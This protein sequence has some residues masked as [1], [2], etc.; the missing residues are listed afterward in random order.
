M[1]LNKKSI[2]ALTLSVLLVLSVAAFAFAEN[3]PYDQNTIL[4]KSVEHPPVQDGIINGH[5]LNGSD[6]LEYG[7]ENP[8][9][10]L[11]KENNGFWAEDMNGNPLDYTLPS[12]IDLY[13]S[14]D[15]D[16]LYAGIIIQESNHT[17][18]Y[19]LTTFLGFG[20]A[21]DNDTKNSGALT[22]FIMNN[23]NSA[24]YDD[25]TWLDTQVTAVSGRKVA[26]DGTITNTT[27]SRRYNKALSYAL[28]YWGSV[29][30]DAAGDPVTIFEV[31]LDFEDAL[32]ASGKSTASVP[33]YGYF[34]FDLNL[35]SGSTQVGVLHCAMSEPAEAENQPDGKIKTVPFMVDLTNEPNPEDANAL[36][37]SIT[38][39]SGSLAE[40]F[41]S[42]KTEYTL[43]LVYGTTSVDVKP[44]PV[45][46]NATSYI[47]GNKDLLPDEDNVITVKVAAKN[48]VIKV[49]KFN[50]VFTYNTTDVYVNASS[51]N[52]STGTGSKNAPY[53]TIAKAIDSKKNGSFATDDAIRV[54]L[55]GAATD[56]SSLLFGES[57]I[58]N[59]DGD[60][61]PIIIE[62]QSGASL[63]L[64]A[65]KVASGN[66]YIFKNLTLN[67]AA[68]SAFYAGSGEVVFENV[69]FGNTTTSFNGD[70]FASSGAFGA[71]ESIPDGTVTSVTFGKGTSYNGTASAVGGETTANSPK[72]VAKV[73][74]DGGTVANVK[75]RT[76]SNVSI[77]ESEVIVKSGATVT[78][79]IGIN[80]S[81]HTGDLAITIGKDAKDTSIVKELVA[82]KGEYSL[83][84]Y[85]KLNVLGGTL[86]EANGSTAVHTTAGGAGTLGTVNTITGGTFKGGFIGVYTTGSMTSVGEVINNV[87]GGNF[88]LSFVGGSAGYNKDVV[89]PKVTNNIGGN[90]NISVQ[91]GILTDESGTAETTTFAFIGASIGNG[92][93]KIRDVENNFSGTANVYSGFGG[94]RIFKAMSTSDF[95]V[96]NI[97]NN[98][99][100][101]SSHFF[102]AGSRTGGAVKT[103][104]NNLSN[105][106]INTFYA[107]SNGTAVN[108]DSTE[109]IAIQTT[110]GKGTTI[111]SFMGGTA[112]ATVNGKIINIVN[113]GNIT[114]FY[115]ASNTG[116]VNG[117]ITSTINDGTITTLYAGTVSG[118]INTSVETTVNGGL[119]TTFYGGNEAGGSI[120]GTVTNT[121][122]GG[123]IATFYGSGKKGNVTGNTISNILGG[124]ITKKFVTGCGGTD[125][126]AG[127]ITTT[128]PAG[129]SAVFEKE[130][131]SGDAAGSTASH[132]TT[133]AGGE[134]YGTASG[135]DIT[136]S[137]ANGS[138][139]IYGSLAC[140]NAAGGT[141]ALILGKNSFVSADKVTGTF[142]IDQKEGWMNEHEYF[143]ANDISEAE[144]V[145]IS[146][147]SG[148]AG[149]YK[150]VT[151]NGYSIVGYS[152][153]PIGAKLILD[154]RVGVKFYYNKADITERFTYVVKL[155]G[156]EIASGS[157][158]DL[159]LEG[160]Y[161]ALVFNGIGLSDFNTEF[162]VIATAMYDSKAAEHN[163]I[164]KLAEL[165]VL[166]STRPNEKAL[167]QSIADLGRVANGENNVHTL[168]YKV[169]TPAPSGERGED[170]ALLTFTGKNLLMN[171][172]I[173]IRLYGQA[174][175]AEDAEDLKVLVDGEDVTSICDISDPVFDGEIYKFSI[176]LFISVSKM[177]NEKSITVYDK[178]DKVCLKLSDQVDWIAQMII[179]NE[180]DNRLAKQVLI[181]I[182]KTHNYINNINQVITPANP[183]N[184][185]EIGD[186][187]ELFD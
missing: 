33:A 85:S 180:P 66:S 1:K 145:V 101:A 130:F 20:D 137:T 158:S 23:A 68:N 125:A 184:E 123:E 93:I 102:Y 14:R 12:Y 177:Q 138:P 88:L 105:T 55:T 107:G 116:T 118:K 61:L 183:G 40:E 44:V 179:N 108:S 24:K 111:G 37:S 139:A 34:S 6:V 110:I 153:S 67:T 144:I 94:A 152:M 80:G 104:T 133:I 28:P 141:G 96:E 143:F 17:G 45:S 98:F 156:K 106:S 46:E 84:G 114:T 147:G 16:A 42:E 9:Y 142:N 129:S 39:G 3:V 166:N 149:S 82:A 90:A 126:T 30:E 113:G 155:D 38:F 124:T 15:E 119:I 69:T 36:L 27:A 22:T 78:S 159:V 174:Q 117:A 51:G 56:T 21:S 49:Y 7:T 91:G 48:G 2:I 83:T 100:G 19:G 165:G 57:T 112:S 187:V 54:L 8:V 146:S 35:Y 148:S 11:T 86:G 97:V 171:D 47:S 131:F 43:N 62:G 95:I 76:S 77:K 176:D 115:G 63:S 181:Y 26:E 128:V 160:N 75:G 58:F 87:T 103:I 31:E 172:A 136:L 151:E 32:L 175:N 173:A 81:T 71:W 25:G 50:V 53:K 185:S 122:K 60:R 10:H 140:E 186:K 134:F 73:I 65:A 169:I 70:D 4:S 164:I 52:D 167:F 121:V 92:A 109:N 170:G 157:Y 127:T 132:S 135:T 161:Y 178:N 163:T 168:G 13:L 5:K 99:T 150:E 120:P 72:I 79:L 64:S 29:S 154:T 182:Q 162:E 18:N 59:N 41:S 74:V 89:I